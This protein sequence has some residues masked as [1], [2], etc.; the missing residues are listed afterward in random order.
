[1]QNPYDIYNDNRAYHGYER[2]KREF[3]EILDTLKINTNGRKLEVIE[4]L[5]EVIDE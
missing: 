1:M 3:K 2:A 4:Q 5:L